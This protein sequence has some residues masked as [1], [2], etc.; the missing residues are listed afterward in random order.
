MRRR[1]AAHL[2]CDD[3]RAAVSAARHEA[4]SADPAGYLDGLWK[5]CGLAGLVCDEGYPQPPVDF[6]QFRAE[7]RVP[8]HR[9]FRIEP[10]ISKLRETAA[11]YD[12]LEDALA[13][14]CEEAAAADAVAFK[15]VLA[16]RT[17]L[18]V[19]EPSAADARAAFLR[20][21]D[22]GFPE[23]RED[24]KPVRDRL[25]ER[26]M[27]VGKA[28][29]RPLHVHCGGGDADVVLEHCSARDLFP[30]LNRHLEHPVVLI[31]SGQP[32]L[33]EG[34]YVAQI[35]PRVYLE[36]SITMP[37]SSLALDGLLELLLGVAPTNKVLYGSD[38]STDPEVAWLS[39][40]VGRAAL[41]RVLTQG[42]RARLGGR[43]RGAAHR[44]RRAR[45]QC[46]A[47]PRARLMETAAEIQERLRAAGLPA[48]RAALRRLRRHLAREVDPARRLESRRALRHRLV[49]H[50]GRRHDRGALR[51]G[52]AVRLAVGRRRLVPDVP[53]GRALPFLPGYAWAPV[54]QFS[55]ELEALPTCPRHVR[56]WRRTGGR[57]GPLGPGHVR[58]RDV[59]APR[60]GAGH[61]G[62]GYSMHR[63]GGPTT[64]PSTCRRA[65]VA[66]RPVEQLHPEYSP[67]Q[68]EVSISPSPP[69]EA[70]DRLLLF[71]F[72][73]RQ[74][75]RRTAW[76]SRSRRR[77]R[78]RASATAATCTCPLARRREPDD[79]R[80]R[81]RRHAARRRGVHRRHPRA[82][83]GADGADRTERAE[84]RRLQPG[85]WA[86]AYTCLGHREPRGRAALHPRH[87]STRSRSANVE[88]K[89]V[90]GAANPYFAVAG[91]LAAGLDG[92]ERALVPPAPL[93]GDPAKLAAAEAA[94]GAVH[95]L[96]ADLA[97][98][99]DA[100]D[101]SASLR[102]ALGTTLHRAIV[103]TRRLEWET[104]REA[105]FEELVAVHRFAY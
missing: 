66:R 90:D 84:L 59:A 2:G 60:H 72:T 69:L 100:L 88:L 62:P 23:T 73:A 76:T 17:G 36:L 3:D 83:A 27:A 74:S 40:T 34:A 54:D 30:F 16:Y 11:S 64:S 68:F 35:L 39:A 19:G 20:W 18:D 8:V 70:A 104:F 103:A 7:A 53:D 77:L 55:Q 79:R 37:W 61:A 25:L 26:V 78:R 56:G 28:T 45:R 96:P 92:V 22:A 38:E 81:A 46:P 43:R 101:A 65:G 6:A 13:A 52:A 57:A 12:E 80:R 9:V 93:Q 49:R 44:H 86:G 99:A 58:G 42:A 48:R 41:E 89:V 85:H 94:R 5:D 95:R 24:A 29:D 82:P 67:G 1:L 32:W 21:R 51:G 98:A 10:A 91:M 4:Y 102:D 87:V 105:S 15:T 31:H 47:A 97:A 75:P 50:L 14:A 33:A 63:A 71:R